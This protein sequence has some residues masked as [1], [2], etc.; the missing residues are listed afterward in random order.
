MFVFKVRNRF[1]FDSPWEIGVGIKL[2][3]MKPPTP[4]QLID[5]LIGDEEQNRKQERKR[6]N[7]GT[8]DHAVASYDPQGSYGELILLIPPITGINKSI[9]I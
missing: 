3:R 2:Q 6:H 8:L 5:A 9:Y 4:T 1:T 7:L